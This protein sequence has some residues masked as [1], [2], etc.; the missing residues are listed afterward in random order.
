MYILPSKSAG[1]F[2]HIFI[3]SILAPPEP[4]PEPEP[5]MAEYQGIHW[6]LCYASDIDLSLH[7]DF[8]YTDL[9]ISINKPNTEGDR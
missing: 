8:A 5:V 1:R 7:T 3:C 9:D 2:A 4:E 6:S